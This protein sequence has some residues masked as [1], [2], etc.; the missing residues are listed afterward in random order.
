MD[1]FGLV[2]LN[3]F[4]RNQ[5][6]HQYA[7]RH[8]PSGV[9]SVGAHGNQNGVAGISAQD[10]ARRILNAPGY[11]GQPVQLDSCNVGRG[12]YPQELSDILGAEVRAPTQ[13]AWYYPSGAV[14]YAGRTA[15]G[16]IDNNAPGALRIFRP[17]R[18]R[19]TTGRGTR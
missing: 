14:I 15:T 2:D 12:Q 9:F 6:I 13:F 16:R 18:Q 4:P 8:N 1:A 11:H 5:L 10:L 7:N 3:L 19:S 17:R